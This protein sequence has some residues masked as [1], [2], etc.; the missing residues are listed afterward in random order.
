LVLA[1]KNMPSLQKSM[2]FGAYTV[3]KYFQDLSSQHFFS[4]VKST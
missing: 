4:F 3:K 2:Y 1:Y